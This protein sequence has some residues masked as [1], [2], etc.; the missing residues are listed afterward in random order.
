MFGVLSH[1]VEV[2]TANE[3][4]HVLP[5]LIWAPLGMNSTSFETREGRKTP[6]RL[7]TEYY[8]HPRKRA[9]SR[10]TRAPGPVLRDRC[11]CVIR[12]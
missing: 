2:L 3:L 6:D 4:E 1:V 9:C 10:V 11:C 12:H 7:S 8:W 5:Q